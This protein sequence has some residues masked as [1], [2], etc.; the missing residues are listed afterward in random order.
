VQQFLD[1]ERVTV[2]VLD[3]QHPGSGGTFADPAER[4][5]HVLACSSLTPQVPTTT[6]DTVRPS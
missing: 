3:Q 2:V 1:E 6:V 5:N 4:T